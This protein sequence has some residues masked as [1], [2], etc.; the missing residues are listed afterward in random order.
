MTDRDQHKPECAYLVGGSCQCGVPLTL[1]E[2]EK[3]NTWD[4]LSD[5][6]KVWNAREAGQWQWYENS[7]CKYVELRIDMR[8]GGCI[9]RNR[10]GKRI[11]PE[12]LAYQF[13]TSRAAAA[14]TGTASDKP[15]EAPPN[16]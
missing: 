2:K 4:H 14:V 3:S 15:D 16:G 12:E 11:M 6:I 7:G 8:D 5:F 9:I 1:E 10:H 13:S